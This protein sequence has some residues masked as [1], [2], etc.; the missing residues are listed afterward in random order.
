MNKK[1][2]VNL[3]RELGSGGRLIGEMLAKRLNIHFY[4]KS[5]IKLA[6]QQSGLSDECFKNVDEHSEKSKLSVLVGLFRSQFA[7][8]NASSDSVLS[9]TTLFQIQSD[10]IRDLAANGSCLFVGRCADYIL[11]D[12]PCA[13]NIFITASREDRINRVADLYEITKEEADQK[14]D[15]EDKSRSDYYNYYSTS[16]WGKASTY[17]L[18]INSSMLGIEKTVDYIASYIES[19]I[20]L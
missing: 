11:R 18:C 3:G 4:D 15:A 6:A 10:V 17:H 16:E 1:Y 5:L 7:M 12:H 13:I 20:S 2:V 9:E 8:L 14:I 19:R